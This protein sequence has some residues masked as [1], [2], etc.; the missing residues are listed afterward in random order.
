MQLLAT[1]VFPAA[2]TDRRAVRDYLARIG[3]GV[4]AYEG[5]TGAITF[6]GRGDVPT[7]SVVVGV[8]RGGRIVTESAP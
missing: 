6:D 3:N 2:G 1:R 4:P 8:V 5:V 7:K